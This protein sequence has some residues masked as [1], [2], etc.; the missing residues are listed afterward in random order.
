MVG[1]A[2]WT[3][4]HHIPSFDLHLALAPNGMC[5]AIPAILAGGR[6][7]KRALDD[8]GAYLRFAYLSQTGTIGV[9]EN[10]LH[11]VPFDAGY[12]APQRHWTTAIIRQPRVPGVILPIGLTL[13]QTERAQS[14]SSAA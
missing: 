14:A 1:G 5:L 8:T 6:H 9:S 10:N 2:I 3:N 7:D 12:I 13:T 11:V 4:K